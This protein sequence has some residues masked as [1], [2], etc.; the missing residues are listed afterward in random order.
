MASSTFSASM[1]GSRSA[2]STSILG[3]RWWTVPLVPTTSLEAVSSLSLLF[4]EHFNSTSKS[5][6]R[7][8]PIPWTVARDFYGVLESF[9][10][11][12]SFFRRSFL[13]WASTDSFSLLEALGLFSAGF[14]A[15]DTSGLAVD[16][17]GHLRVSSVDVEPAGGGFSYPG[18]QLPCF[19]M[20]L[21]PLF[22]LP[23]VLA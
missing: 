1:V 3:M 13:L 4:V 5:L 8:C 11:F 14:F 20:L 9:F 10:S 7:V 23:S 22:S 17:L 21:L 6:E 19:W 16:F 12:F 18:R 15:A 2:I